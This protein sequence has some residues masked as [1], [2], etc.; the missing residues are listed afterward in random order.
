MPVTNAQPTGAFE[1]STTPVS[2]RTD[3]FVCNLIRKVIFEA[4][5]WGLPPLCCLGYFPLLQEQRI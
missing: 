4:D 5:D 2:V 1:T 3:S